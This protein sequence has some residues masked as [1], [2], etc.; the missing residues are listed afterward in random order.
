MSF[1]LTG[2]DDYCLAATFPSG[3]DLPDEWREIGTVAETREPGTVT[4]DGA[5]YEQ[6]GG[7]QHFR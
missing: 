6:P 1:V 5:E 2:G 4:V 3:T 7:H